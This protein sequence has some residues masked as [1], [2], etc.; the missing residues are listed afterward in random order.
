MTSA[1]VAGR[2]TAP[3]PVPATERRRGREQHRPTRS[4]AAERRRRVRTRIIVA[5]IAYLVTFLVVLP[6]LWIV[7]LSFQQSDQILSDPFSVQTLTLENYRDA[8]ATLP[9]VQMYKNTIIIAAVAVTIG[10]TVSF[11]ASFALTRMV[12][13]RRGVQSAL[14]LYFLA[15]LAVPVY[16]LL[17]P[18]YRLDLALGIFGTYAAVILPYAVVSIPFNTLLL[19]GF[20]RGMPG[21]LEEAAI[22]DGAGL[23]RICWSVV[24]PVMRPIL[25]TVVI[26][27]V[28]YVFN[29]FPFVSVLINDP[30]LATVSLAVSKFQGQYSVNYGGMMAA[31]T[32]V[33]LPQLAI[34]A[35]LQRHVIAGLTA[36]AVK[37]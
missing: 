33:L 21:E 5:G 9:L 10:T 17:F 37:G 23:F 27:N 18:V 36:G 34:Y 8:I 7:L 22:I 6:I 11:M 30:D 16:V 2:E 31:A 20:L 14:L 13:R 12:F 1:T 32:L 26:F 3:P 35:V 29:E 28:V 4:P 25:A 19:T 15:G 24:L